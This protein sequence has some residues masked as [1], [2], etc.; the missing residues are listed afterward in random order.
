MS[1]VLGAHQPARTRLVHVLSCTVE[2]R[3][4]GHIH[5]ACNCFLD[6]AR[7]RAVSVVQI[8]RNEYDQDS[9]VCCS[10]REDTIP[11]GARRK[12]DTEREDDDECHQD[13]QSGVI[14]S[15][16][17]QSNNRSDQEDHCKQDAK[18]SG[19]RRDKTVLE[20][21]R[22]VGMKIRPLTHIIS[23]V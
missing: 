17:V 14:T 13:S 23:P 19:N 11:V 10:R 4:D 15:H 3:A 9:S 22:I 20:K 1:E 7:H 5:G 12:S 21:S 2:R 8:P 16:I 6:R 18:R